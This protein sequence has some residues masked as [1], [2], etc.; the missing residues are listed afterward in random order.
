[1]EFLNRLAE[2]LAEDK[3]KNDMSRKRNQPRR[4]RQRLEELDLAKEVRYIQRRAAERDGR[5]VTVGQLAF[6]SCETGDAWML[7]PSDRLAARL[8][9]DGTP[10]PIDFE[11]AETT[12]TISW[13]GYYR[14]DDSAFVYTDQTSGR[15]VTIFGYPTTQIAQLG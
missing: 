5:F 7:D 6:F 4:C 3:K 15:V 14:I 13:K 8:A 1:V 2:H 11:E 12:F 9:R 10:E